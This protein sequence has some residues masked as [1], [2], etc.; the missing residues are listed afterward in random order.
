VVVLRV[1]AVEQAEV[2]STWGSSHGSWGSGAIPVAVR[3]LVEEERPVG[4]EPMVGGAAA[5][6]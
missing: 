5:K 2:G 1:E 3:Q 6:T 4:Q